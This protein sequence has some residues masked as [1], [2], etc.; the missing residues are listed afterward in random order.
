MDAGEAIAEVEGVVDLGFVG[1]GYAHDEGGEGD[2]LDTFELRGLDEDASVIRAGEALRGQADAETAFR[3]ADDVGVAKVAEVK[4]VD[5][6]CADD[7][8]VSKGKEL[9]AADK[10]GVEARDAGAGDGAGVGVVEAVVVDEVVGGE[11]AEAAV[12]VDADGTLVVADGL[13]EG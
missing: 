9:R 3:L 12:A 10:E 2:V 5:G 8:G 7:L 11:L 6:V 1:D 13:G 4:L